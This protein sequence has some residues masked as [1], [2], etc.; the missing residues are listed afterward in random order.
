MFKITNHKVAKRETLISIA[1]KYKHQSWKTIWDDKRNAKVKKLR[2]SPEAIDVG[3]VLVIP[4]NETQKKAIQQEALRLKT[5]LDGEQIVIEIIQKRAEH[6]QKAAEKLNKDRASFDKSFK[7]MIGLL[8]SYRKDSKKWK[9]G[10]DI[11]NK[12]INLLRGLKGLSKTAKSA[13]KASGDELA[14]LNGKMASDAVEFVTQPVQ[15]ILK[16]AAIKWLLNES[17]AVSDVGRTVGTVTKWW[18]EVGSPSFWADGVSRFVVEKNYSIEGWTKALQTDF[19]VELTSKIHV[20]E[21]QYI[22]FMNDITKQARAIETESK[23]LAK[24]VGATVKRVNEYVKH[25]KALPVIGQ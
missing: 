14:K 1:K 21:K 9:D 19:E 4:F 23:N 22:A 2:K 7:A 24:E 12:V 6:L 10:I 16:D 13:S 18:G 15:D 17:N 8:E 20:I 11:A 25:V 3:D 5:K